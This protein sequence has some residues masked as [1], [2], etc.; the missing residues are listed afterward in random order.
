M[1]LEKIHPIQELAFKSAFNEQPDAGKIIDYPNVLL[2]GG[3]DVDARLDLMRYLKDDF[4]FG[5][6]GTAPE[7]QEK[8]LEEGFDYHPYVM[9]RR[10]HPLLDLYSISQLVR[11]FRRLKPDIVHT[12]DAKPCVWV[13]LAAHW[14]G[15]PVTIGTL[16]GLSSL[17]SSNRPA[18]QLMRSIYQPLQ[19]FASHTSDLTIFQNHDDARR[20]IDDGVVP[21]QKAAV[22][23]GSG[24]RTD[25]FDPTK[26][27][28]AERGQLR[29]ELG[30][31]PDETMVTMISRVIRSKG[32]LEF[33]AA[34]WHVSAHY[35][36]VR[37]VLVGAEDEES[38]YRLD[39]TELTQLANTVIWPGPRRDIPVVL[40]AS[41]IFMFPTAH[42]EG[43]PRVLLEAASMALPIITTDL[44]GCRE[45]VEDGVNGL[46]IPVRNSKALSEALMY[47]IERTDLRQRFG[48]I[49][50]QKAIDRFDLSIIAGQTRQ[51]YR[52]LL[53][54]K[55]LCQPVA[56]SREYEV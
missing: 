23:P 41:D 8:F 36:N 26:I 19:K 1:S 9:H 29:Q 54:Q 32:V 2:A 14:A 38:I 25:L 3:P 24:I 10:I 55:G 52:Q 18:V 6:M 30:I 47:L 45:V 11:L 35:P 12:F 27:S 56:N 28:E 16:T 33:M 40:A 7:L 37:F 31:A 48:K 44:P 50:R 39:A 43:I 51:V 20:F 17:Y 42:R 46:L 34:A 4:K 53:K 13:R 21:E 49:S 15:V 5:A 22:I